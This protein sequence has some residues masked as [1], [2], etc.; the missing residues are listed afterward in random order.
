V[1]PLLRQLVWCVLLGTIVQSLFA[2]ENRIVRPV[3]PGRTTILMQVPQWARPEY[4]QGPIA[5]STPLPYV[6]LQLQPAAG[7]EQFLATQ[8]TPSSPNYRRWLTPEQFADRFGL[9]S[10]DVAKLVAWLQSQGLQ[11]QDVARGRHWITFSGTAQQV[12]RAFRTEIHRYQVNGKLYRGNSTGLSIPEAFANVVRGVAGLD[13]F[14]LQPLFQLEQPAPGILVPQF[15]SGTS[16]YLAPDDFATIYNLTPLYNAG[17]DGTGQKIA[18]I[19]QSAINLSDV[20]Q[21]RQTFNLPPN[22]PQPVLFGP[23]P[24]I[25]SGDMLEADLDL[26][27][28]GSVA[29]QATILYVYSTDVGIAAQYAVDQ[30]LAPVMT[31][32]YGFCEAY[33]SVAFRAI[34]QQANAQGITWMTAAGDAGAASCD[35]MFSPTPQASLGP[36][37]SFPA[38]LPEITAVGGTQ[39]NDGTGAGFWAATNT[40]NGASALSYVPESA[41]NTS[42]LRI[43]LTAGGGGPSILFS[44]PSWQTGP[45]VPNDNARDTPDL[46]LAASPQHYPYIVYSGGSL[47]HVGGTSAASPVFAGIVALLNHY[48]VSNGSQTQPGLGNINP[49]LYRLARNTTDVFHDITSGDNRVPCEQGS[50]ACTGSGMGYAAGPGYDLA[51][52]LGTVDAYHLVTEWKTASATTTTLTAAPSAVSLTDTVTL[53]VTVTANAG[54]PTG[55]VTFLTN[56]MSLGSATL[57]PQGTATLTAPAINLAAG[58]G[59][60]TAL[61]SGDAL[62]DGSAA[63]TAITLN[64]PESGSLVVPF[65]SPNPVPQSGSVWRYTVGLSEKAGVATTLTGFTINGVQQNLAF[66]TSANI[67]ANGTITADLAASGLTVP[68]DRVFAFT[69]QD[70][71]GQAWTQQITV[72]FVAGPGPVLA[73]SITLSAPSTVRQN[74]QADPSCQWSQPLTVQ[75]TGGFL[76]QLASLRAGSANW[77]S[78]IQTLFGTTRLAPFG[79]LRAMLCFDSTTQLGTIPIQVIGQSELGTFVAATVSTTLAA[80]VSAPPALAVSSPA[81]QIP[82]DSSGQAGPATI[83]VAFNGPAPAWSA[84]ILPAN[85]TSSWLKVSTTPSGAALLASTAGLPNGVFRAIVSIEAPDAVPSAISVPVTMVVG[86][87]SVLKIFG[88]RNNASGTI[89]FAP[90]MQVAV[91]GAGLAPS[92]QVTSHIPL[93]FQLAGVSATVNGISAPV[94]SV[95]PGQVDIQIP[96]ETGLGSAVLAINNNGQVASFSF[97]VSVAAPGIYNFFLDNNTGAQNSGLAGDVMTMFVSGVGDL[98]PSLATGATPSSFTPVPGLPVAR[99]PLTVAVGGE[100]APVAFAGNASGLVGAIQI[101]FTAPADLA[102]GPQPVIVTV[103]TAASDPVNLTIAAP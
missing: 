59:T 19:G 24:G 17:T 5:P 82:V 11:V 7:L 23:D 32:S 12:S 15:S 94:Y 74:P 76:I 42:A 90:G 57:S 63:T 100:T 91:Y 99:L 18:V 80:A 34:A 2:A 52:G 95:S 48:L 8:R 29:R 9:S 30:N 51:T 37:A 64:L 71:G 67:P 89:A 36:A 61:Y 14:G 53:A 98:T 20:R 75:E 92:T 43:D 41:W 40:S 79:M 3:D 97:P 13:D 93:P 26:E 22:D 66:W 77:S 72:P 62:F 31:L 56:D 68:L 58:N 28:A 10:E 27:W 70:P 96:Y 85:R 69:G 49:A 86:G 60:I 54:A 21:F 55:I 25:R 16:R 73:P 33:T 103:G 38:S 6:T 44:K 35:Q 84:T 101:N 46:S 4:D 81:V 83:G 47:I 45:G 50:P 78:H 88:M 39:F 1:K 65:V 87:S 102:P